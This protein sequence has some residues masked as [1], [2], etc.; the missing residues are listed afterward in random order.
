MK[1]LFV[2][3][4]QNIYKSLKMMKFCKKTKALKFILISIF[5]SRKRDGEVW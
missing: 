1:E 4:A 3:T 5:T 2:K